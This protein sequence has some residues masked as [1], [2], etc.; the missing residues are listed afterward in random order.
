MGK[1]AQK[2]H[3]KS[4][5][6]F[7]INKPGVGNVPELDYRLHQVYNVKGGKPRMWW[8]NRKNHE[9]RFPK[10]KGDMVLC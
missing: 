9:D 8:I 1:T 10:V 7:V 6:E 2:M 3:M 5:H 4:K